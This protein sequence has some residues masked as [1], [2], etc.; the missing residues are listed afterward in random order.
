[1]VIEYFY[2]RALYYSTTEVVVLN[3]P[4]FCD[5]ITTLG[6][7]RRSES[8]GNFRGNLTEGLRGGL[9]S[10]SGWRVMTAWPMTSKV[11][12]GPAKSNFSDFCRRLTARVLTQKY[13]S[14]L[15]SHVNLEGDFFFPFQTI[16]R[17]VT[18]VSGD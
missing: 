17:V 15:K 8:L 14:D 2:Y 10:S 11:D 12:R 7:T 5:T 3:I 13:K 18:A 1:M 16:M 6:S 4:Y 9:G